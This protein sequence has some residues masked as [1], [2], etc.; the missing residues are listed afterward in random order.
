MR[1]GRD[2]AT[3]LTDSDHGA[4]AA[5]AFAYQ[6]T[7]AACLA[8]QMVAGTGLVAD[9]EAVMCEQRDD[10]LIECAN[11]E[12]IG[13]EVKAWS[14]RLSTDETLRVVRRFA[15]SEAAYP[16]RYRQFHLQTIVGFTSIGD[17]LRV[18]A[19]HVRAGA[20][21]DD[22]VAC[23]A[24]AI[25]RIDPDG[26]LGPDVVRSMLAKLRMETGLA[27]R[28]DVTRRLREATRE[29][30]GW[31]ERH[32]VAA[33][34][35]V[36]Q[37]AAAAGRV[38]PASADPERV[39]FADDPEAQRRKT[40]LELRRLDQRRV[41]EA[42]A[43]VA[44]PRGLGFRVAATT[45]AAALLL[46]VGLAAY[47]VGRP[48]PPAVE[49]LTAGP[50]ALTVPR[51]W[52]QAHASVATVRGLHLTERAVALRPGVVLVAGRID[53]AR[54]SL[55]PAPASLRST[56]SSSAPPM[57]TA[58]GDAL[59]Y[60][61]S[62]ADGRQQLL[63]LYPA[64]DGW[65]A[66]LC[67]SSDPSSMAS[68]EGVVADAS[69]PAWLRRTVRPTPAIARAVDATL[70]PLT[71]MRSLAQHDFASGTVRQRHAAA[72]SL[73]A[74]TRAVRG[75]LGAIHAGPYLD[76]ALAPA[77]AALRREARALDRLAAAAEHRRHAS[78]DRAAKE[79]TASEQSLS[80][81]LKRVG[82]RLFEA[83]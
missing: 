8:V 40:T 79:V 5:D 66:A 43:G 32:V 73:A 61:A 48:S 24:R 69:L 62:L 67:Q 42:I 41:R 33:A 16:H 51:P 70:A 10:V 12:R 15:R 54:H 65:F 4:A 39:A 20:R 36:E 77:Q 31:D 52:H 82:F 81:A 63:L 19:G 23:V 27:K 26:E 11:G 35:A 45:L 28:E 76:V 17:E 59:A 3:E 44:P 13:I 74:T 22:A 30:T 60:R 14:G 2:P 9:A 53:D 64:A 21:A 68:C 46:G 25:D 34:G 38:H 78:Y 29:L 47:A 50:L 80:D 83:D 72:R 49:R 37:L 71:T 75:N 18:A 55:D 58:A 57:A 6:A 56:W 1:P 7:F